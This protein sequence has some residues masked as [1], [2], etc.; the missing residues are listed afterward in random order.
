[1]LS[2]CVSNNQRTKSTDHLDK[3][4][5]FTLLYVR[6]MLAKVCGRSLSGI[7]VSSPAGGM[8]VSLVNVVCWAEVS[9]TG[10]SL[11]QRS[12]TDS[13]ASLCVL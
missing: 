12:P 10:R 9:G 6:Y 8:V 7:A 3:S 11:D 5:Y 4:V 13:F 2:R 1:M